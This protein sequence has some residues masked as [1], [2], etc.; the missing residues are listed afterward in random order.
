M[1]LPSTNPNDDVK[2]VERGSAIFSKHGD[3]IRGVIRYHAKNEAQADDIFQDF[4][5]SL[6]SRPVPTNIQNIKSYLYR[7]IT[8]DIVDGTR[9][10]EKYQGRMHRYAERLK[11]SPTE[12]NPENAL[13]R[14]E[15]TDKIVRLIERR[16]R[17]SEAQ[18]V[19]L[20]YR[21]DYKI[22]D[23][24]AQM[25]VNNRTVTGYVSTGLKKIRRF[26]GIR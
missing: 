21:N 26:L 19:I 9:R 25:G 22:K 11:Y 20:R 15:E 18:A 5:L 1:A 7:A 24:A 23:I 13:I 17:R 6:V 16:L 14:N 4:F 8:N 2:G 12:D 3:F 10:I